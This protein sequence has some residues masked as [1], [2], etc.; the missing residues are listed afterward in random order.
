[1]A[2]KIFKEGR[3]T[4]YLC[5]NEEEYNKLRE[6]IDGEMDWE[7][8]K[9][10][11]IGNSSW[12]I[13]IVSF[14]HPYDQISSYVLRPEYCTWSIKDIIEKFKTTTV[15]IPNKTINKQRTTLSTNKQ[16]QTIMATEKKIQI[17]TKKN[18]SPVYSNAKTASVYRAAGTKHK[19]PAMVVPVQ[20]VT[21]PQGFYT[22]ATKYLETGKPY[23]GKRQ[24]NTYVIGCAFTKN[25]KKLYVVAQLTYM[26]G[27]PAI[28]VNHYRGYS[29]R[30]A[31]IVFN[32]LPYHEVKYTQASG[33][34]VSYKSDGT[35]HTAI[36]QNI[37]RRQAFYA[38]RQNGGGNF[39]SSA[40]GAS[41]SRR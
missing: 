28:A 12:P 30:T 6:D 36:Q 14:N 38:N 17:G 15:P 3:F 24:F 20:F 1:M 4:Y 2:R 21:L 7:E 35:Y 16:N 39:R 33:Q 37:R 41:F 13:K 9:T 34:S 10:I 23:N 11:T 25:N 18:G 31:W 40:D 8:V 19:K 32:N 27:K 5:K 29:K 22:H 26:G